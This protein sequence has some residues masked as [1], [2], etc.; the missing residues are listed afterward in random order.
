M[1]TCP[2]NFAS[3]E[4]M[5]LARLATEQYV[6]ILQLKADLKAALE[7]FRKECAK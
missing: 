4:H 1:S 5:V 7:A 3:W 6:E 2:H